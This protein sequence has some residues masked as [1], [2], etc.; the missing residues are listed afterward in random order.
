MPSWKKLITSGSDAELNSL[1]APSITGSL[2][3]TASWAQNS[4]SSSYA[5]TASYSKNLQMSGSINNVDYIDFN[6]GSAV[7][8]WKSGRVF[9]DNVD[10]ALS[11]YNAEADITLQVGQENW[12]RVRNNT[13]TAVTN[14]TVV[15]IIGSQGD[16][17]T[18]ER[19]QSI[20]KSG[21][22]NVDTQILGVATHN[23]E[24]NS[25]GYITTQGLVRGLNTNA[26][27]DGD[28]LFV[29][30][31]SSGILTNIPPR[32]PYEII[33]VGTCVKASPGASGIIYV[34]VQQP[35]DF[36]DLSSVRVTGSYSYGDLWVYRQSGSFGVWEHTNQLSGSY[37][38]TGSL[39][40]TA[41]ITGSLYT[42]DLLTIAPTSPLPTVTN[43]AIA[44]SS[45]GDFY[46][47]SGSAW[48]KLTL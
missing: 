46:F 17:P 20:A 1:Y 6:T 11:V 26:F 18:I 16:A 43:G 27:N 37:V 48:R 7:P 15:R 33:V 22:I 29:G 3:G 40:V 34:A 44:F 28:T 21:S 10:G 45:S 30:T 35:L 32:A 42:R 24:D 19:A 8:A 23:I 4:I 9:W 12:T 2:H 47:G 25:F 13:G 39:N 14:G 38:I 36:S 31:G 41:G 5:L